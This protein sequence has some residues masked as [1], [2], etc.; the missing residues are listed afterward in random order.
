MYFLR[1]F[2]RGEMHKVLNY[3]KNNA[4]NFNSKLENR[5]YSKYL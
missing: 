2:L 5:I 3:I 1:E 4:W